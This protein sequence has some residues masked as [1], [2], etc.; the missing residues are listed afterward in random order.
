MDPRLI[1]YKNRIVFLFGNIDEETASDII[2]RLLVMNSL[3][4]DPIKMFIN[5][6]GGEISAGMAIYDTMQFIE[7]P[8]YTI[9]IG[10][11]ASMAAW[12]LAAGKPGNRVASENSQIMIHQ[13]RTV[14]GGN[15][16]DLKIN[17]EEFERTQERLIKILS[18]H[19]GKSFQDIKDALERDYWMT[20]E[21]ALNFGIIDRVVNYGETDSSLYE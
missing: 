11:C 9:C 5:S 17:M 19:S 13:G 8:V 6:P 16:S 20:P 15:Y 7:S 4:T 12:L 18:R 1:L 3:G 21:D 2:P 10:H 14:M